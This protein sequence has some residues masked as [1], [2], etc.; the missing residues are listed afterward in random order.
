MDEVVVAAT[1]SSH[2]GELQMM[3]VDGLDLPTQ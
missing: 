2:V 1:Q 3:G